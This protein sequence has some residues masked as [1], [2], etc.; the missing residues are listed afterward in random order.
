MRAKKQGNQLLKLSCIAMIFMLTLALSLTAG[1]GINQNAKLNDYASAAA[2]VDGNNNYKFSLN[3]NIPSGATLSNIYAFNNDMYGAFY[4]T[5]GD[6]RDNSRDN[7]L[8]A[9]VRNLKKG[10]VF[11]FHAYFKLPSELSAISAQLKLDLEYTI[12]SQSKISDVEASLMSV[13]EIP[14]TDG[15]ASGS[16]KKLLTP[17]TPATHKISGDKN[18]LYSANASNQYIRI[19][20]KVALSEDAGQWAGA[21]AQAK[22]A[23][24]NIKLT[25]TMPNDG[26]GP[27]VTPWNGTDLPQ[28]GYLGTHSNGILFDTY[29]VANNSLVNCSEIGKDDDVKVNKYVSYKNNNG[30]PIGQKIVTFNVY[31]KFSGLK[32]VSFG[33]YTLPI[34]ADGTEVTTLREAWLASMLAS[35]G[36]HDEINLQGIASISTLPFGYA[37][38]AA[39]SGTFRG[40]QVKIVYDGKKY[41]SVGD[42][43]PVEMVPNLYNITA[44]DMAGQL[45]TTNVTLGGIDTVSPVAPIVKFKFADN[46]WI[47]DINSVDFTA[48]IPQ[49]DYMGNVTYAYSLDFSAEKLGAKQPCN[50]GVINPGI[51][52]AKKYT[53]SNLRNGYYTFTLT[54]VDGAGNVGATSTINFNI[55]TSLGNVANAVQSVKSNNINYAGATTRLPIDV[56][57][58]TVY[59]FSGIT[60][61]YRVANGDNSWTNWTDIPQNA[62]KMTFGS[63]TV[64][65]IKNN[66]QFRLVTGAGQ[67][68]FGEKDTV[69]INFDN[70]LPGRI[71][72]VNLDALNESNPYL[73]MDALKIYFD[74]F[75]E[76]L[77]NSSSISTIYY[78]VGNGTIYSA[79]YKTAQQGG[80]L[81]PLYA[82][83]EQ[84]AKTK[85]LK[86]VTMWAADETGELSEKTITN[87]YVDA[88]RLF[89]EFTVN[90]LDRFYNATNNTDNDL[91]YKLFYDA[92]RNPLGD[93]SGK[94]LKEAYYTLAKDAKITINYKLN[95]T[96]YINGAK[97]TLEANAL[98][99]TDFRIASSTAE[100]VTLTA[101][102][103]VTN[104][105]I[106]NFKLDFIT[107]F[108]DVNA[109]LDKTI[110]LASL[111]DGSYFTLEGTKLD[112]VVI[113]L[114][115]ALNKTDEN[116]DATGAIIGKKTI[117]KAQLIMM[118]Q[119]AGNNN[120]L[121][122]SAPNKPYDGT[123]SFD[124]KAQGKNTFYC[125]SAFVGTPWHNFTWSGTFTFADKNVAYSGANIADKTAA[126]SNVVFVGAG[127]SAE[128][129]EVVGRRDNGTL[130]A[131]SAT[132]PIETKGKIIPREL[133]INAKEIILQ[134][135][136][137]KYYDGTDVA[138][139][140]EAKTK[141]TLVGA[142][143]A[144]DGIVLGDVVKVL[145]ESATFINEKAEPNKTVTVKFGGLTGLN[146]GNYSFDKNS[147]G[148]V[149]INNIEIKKADLKI[150]SIT[151]PSKEYDGN[152]NVVGNMAYK[153]IGA[154]GLDN[155]VFSFK[156]AKFV[157]ATKN[158]ISDIGL[159]DVQFLMSITANPG[160]LDN[161][162]ITYVGTPL[163]GSFVDMQLLASEKSRIK[164]NN[165]TVTVNVDNK[166]FDNTLNVINPTITITGL[167]N[168]YIGVEDV[169]GNVIVN[170][171]KVNIPYVAFVDKNAGNNVK[172]VFVL[173][174]FVQYNQA[175]HGADAIRYNV[176]YD[177]KIPTATE[178]LNGAFVLSLPIFDSTGAD[179]SSKYAIEYKYE[180][181]A[182]IAKKAATATITGLI[183]TREDGTVVNDATNLPLILNDVIYGGFFK[184]KNGNLI[185]RGASKFNV[186][187]GNLIDGD[188]N[189]AFAPVFSN[190]ITAITSVGSYVY[191]ITDL[192][193]VNYDFTGGLTGYNVS[194]SKKAITVT[195]GDYHGLIFRNQ[196]SNINTLNFDGI[197][198]G[199]FIKVEQSW[200]RIFNDTNT[201]KLPTAADLPV[202][203]YNIE[204]TLPVQ[205]NYEY[206][207]GNG[208]TIDATKL[209]VVKQNAVTISKSKLTGIMFIDALNIY[210]GNPNTIRAEGKIPANAK[211]TY[212]Y[213]KL[214]AN[215][216][217]GELVVSAIDAGMYRVKVVI[218]KGDNVNASDYE[219]AYYEDFADLTVA[220]ATI[221]L[222]MPNKEMIFKY[223]G[224]CHEFEEVVMNPANP[225]GISMSDIVFEYSTSKI[226]TDI[227]GGAPDVVG[228][229]Y[230][231][232]VF[233]GNNNYAS[234][235]SEPRSIRIEPIEIPVTIISGTQ[236]SYSK[237]FD[238]DGNLITLVDDAGVEYTFNGIVLS[239]TEA[240]MAFL[241][242]VS[243]EYLVKGTY[244]NKV[245]T[246]VG[247]YLFRITAE[248]NYVVTGKVLSGAMVIGV[249]SVSDTSNSATVGAVNGVLPTVE[250]TD[251]RFELRNYVYDKNSQEAKN[252]NIAVKNGASILQ[253]DFLIKSLYQ[254]YLVSVNADEEE[255]EI[256]K[257]ITP[258]VTVRYAYNESLKDS[259][260][261]VRIDYDGKGNTNIVVMDAVY[262]AAAGGLIFETDR[263]GYF[264]I[265]EK[266][267]AI[268]STLFIGL[269]IGAVIVFLLGI[270]LFI[271]ML[272]RRQKKR[273]QA[274]LASA[275][276][277]GYS[278]G[279]SGY[280]MDSKGEVF[281]DGQN[282]ADENIDENIDENDDEGL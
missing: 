216:Q 231:R 251:I 153:A 174:E 243:V 182:N 267:S 224:E 278:S 42:L 195:V 189:I 61:Q 55:D 275:N 12:A 150:E 239:T 109:G 264:A 138:F 121:P 66:Y 272:A 261:L 170:G 131:L 218:E 47:T 233:K 141:I 248:E 235:Q 198:D 185:K 35:V 269:I 43:A 242:H 149:T 88:P 187:Y 176:T 65:Q 9:N 97:F 134:N 115:D 202:G 279:N 48:E 60:Y 219:Y 72:S 19:G 172:V 213:Y 119:K 73:G 49:A 240:N 210:S 274:Q 217:L 20:F 140:D 77:A 38:A 254:T 111:N 171:K 244:S 5:G 69:S 71:Y 83:N 173:G 23:I 180:I 92:S 7:Q 114:L 70:R 53:L 258:T 222:I 45:S 203:V 256:K 113:V 253:G 270:A 236:F 280:E 277:G 167:N 126:L 67:I 95:D 148:V 91:S 266:A 228:V 112:N 18:E 59:C 262:D 123:L 144:A 257:L 58:S 104:V 209:I 39:K 276:V 125:T 205:A 81:L 268:T 11:N 52:Y 80:A 193:H 179:V 181:T 226:F 106:S 105:K 154:I 245:P 183:A 225:Y 199:D 8:S 168:A 120:V 196:L 164:R 158:P 118:Q 190:S 139:I 89:L 237:Y 31:D 62:S 151:A 197:L 82:P 169:N 46:S 63:A 160:A 78:Q 281:G 163:A 241:K 136:N 232:A 130:Y 200:F 44:T 122:V 107:K 79:D 265:V 249:D 94:L 102:N 26:N 32:S 223:D 142:T 10:G 146:A 13:S 166:T 129:F 145:L 207:V 93:I 124:V 40:V 86:T 137:Y 208:Y 100:T 152:V 255:V 90:A 162:L 234:S 68:V 99:N 29:Y 156:D 108:D 175:Q 28:S 16:A 221:S 227:Y 260:K 96:I 101:I 36:S 56:N 54:T 116:V 85:T 64:E 1:L 211:V 110:S 98:A 25:I 143:V 33:G 161:Y 87:V 27:T 206:V 76:D 215:G 6:I 188:T 271:A 75:T 132:T 191:N 186:V 30:Q 117:K 4:I 220:K 184:D 212:F 17:A 3:G 177:G 246:K 103:K 24:N 192:S 50:T 204:I 194:V 263:L 2:S 230:V 135:I 15:G 22:I 229:Y 133:V 14:T 273:F 21:N 178:N 252:F 37:T 41:S 250:G 238:A 165:L 128:N 247:S 57:L 214:L 51:T 34:S 147:A 201:S 282:E 127:Y 74:I 84:F 157:D 159:Y 259:Q 155:I